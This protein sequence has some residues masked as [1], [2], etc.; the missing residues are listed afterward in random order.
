MGR[1]GEQ[2]VNVVAEGQLQAKCHAA[3]AAAD[4][5]RQIDEQ[6]VIGIDHAPCLRELRFQALAGYGIAEEQRARVFI[7]DK[8]AVRVGF[9]C[10]APL[11]DRHAIVLF[12]LNHRY[13]VAAQFG[14]FP[15]PGIGGHMHRDLKTN[16][17]AHDADRHPKVAGGADGDAELAKELFKLR[18]QQFAIIV[19]GRQQPGFQRQLFRMGQHFINPTARFD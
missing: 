18:R 6:R 1:F 13:A 12:I 2:A 17:R 16:A 14:F 15:R 9:R 5:A 8:K 10:L 7:I 19:C 11:F 4:A 3:G